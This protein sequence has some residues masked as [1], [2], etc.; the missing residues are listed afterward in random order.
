VIFDNTEINALVGDKVQ[1]KINR[2]NSATLFG[3]AIIKF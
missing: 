1:V 2:A 3:D